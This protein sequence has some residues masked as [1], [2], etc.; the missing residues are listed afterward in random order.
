MVD[1]HSPEDKPAFLDPKRA[2]SIPY[3]GADEV[4]NFDHELLE[5][6]ENPEAPSRGIIDRY[7]EIARL[8]ARGWTNN[9]ICKHLGYTASRMSVIL[10]DPFVQDEI[11]KWRKLHFDTETLGILK[12]AAKDGARLLHKTIMDEGARESV[13]TDAAKFAIEKTHGKAR[14]E[15]QIESGTLLS[16]MELMREV[17]EQ[18]RE[19]GPSAEGGAPLSIQGS[20]AKQEADPFDQWLDQNLRSP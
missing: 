13:R 18:P 10:K 12:E 3:V 14:Q 15:V 4:P 20:D 8:H 19:V 16:F 6:N 7:R 11:K 5:D 17:R 2:E 1:D 9:Q